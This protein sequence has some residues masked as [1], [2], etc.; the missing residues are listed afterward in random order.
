MH[1]IRELCLVLQKFLKSF[2]I[3]D[4]ILYGMTGLINP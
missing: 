4:K 3:A 2:I 1:S